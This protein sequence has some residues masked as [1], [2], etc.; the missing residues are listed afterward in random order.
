MFRCS[1]VVVIVCALTLYWGVCQRLID[2][3]HTGTAGGG[4]DEQSSGELMSAIRSLTGKKICVQ[5]GACS[6]ELHHCCLH[7]DANSS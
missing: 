2:A 3:P 7:S 1:Y 5:V 4:S 6:I